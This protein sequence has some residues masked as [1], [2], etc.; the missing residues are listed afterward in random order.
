MIIY[1]GKKI[2]IRKDEI[3]LVDGRKGDEER[4]LNIRVLPLLFHL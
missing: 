2:N 4:L 1:S 3:V